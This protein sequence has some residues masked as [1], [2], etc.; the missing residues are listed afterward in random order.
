MSDPMLS[1]LYARVYRSK[2]RCE[3]L[4]HEKGQHADRERCTAIA[5]NK[6]LCELIDLRTEQ[7][8]NGGGK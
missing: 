2:A 1:E 7:I 8:R 5:I 6:L 4:T 3:F